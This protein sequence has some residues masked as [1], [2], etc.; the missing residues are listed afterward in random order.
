V[1]IFIIICNNKL[2]QGAVKSFVFRVFVSGSNYFRLNTTLAGCSHDQVSFISIL[3]TSNEDEVYVH[4]ILCSPDVNLNTGFIVQLPG[5]ATRAVRRSS[6]RS[7]WIAL[8]GATASFF[9]LINCKSLT[10]TR[11]IFRPKLLIPHT[12]ASWISFRW[13][14]LTDRPANG[15]IAQLSSLTIEIEYLAF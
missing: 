10:S 15:R 6:H 5:H 9:N 7:I 3:L 4:F 2:A 1:A 14:Y 11:C 8:R 12:S 13:P